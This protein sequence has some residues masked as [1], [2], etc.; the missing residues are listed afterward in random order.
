MHHNLY[1]VLRHA[2][3]PLGLDHLKALV[4]HCG[5]VDGDLAAHAPVGV[6]E[7]ILHRGCGQPLAWPCAERATRGREY[8]LAHAVALF[9][10]QALVE[11]SVLRVDGVQV[12]LR[13]GYKLGDEVARHHKCLFVGQRYV[14]ACLYGLD[15]GLKAAVAHHGCDHN[16]DRWLGCGFGNGLATGHNLDAARGQ[17]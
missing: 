17:G 13:P 7:S 12:R 3:E 9:A 10:H 8:E 1:V 11:G 16:V 6:V 14:F 4:H 15:C 5:T 2:V